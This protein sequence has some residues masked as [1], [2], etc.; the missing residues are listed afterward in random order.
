M[1]KTTRNMQ[2]MCL[3][4]RGAPYKKKKKNG[5]NSVLIMASMTFFP[6]PVT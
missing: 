6:I 4:E 1:D 2:M 3:T 5:A